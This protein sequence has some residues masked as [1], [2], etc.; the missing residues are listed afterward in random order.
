MYSSVIATILILGEY[1]GTDNILYIFKGDKY[2]TKIST[3]SEEYKMEY[4]QRWLRFHFGITAGSKQF[5]ALE[6]CLPKLFPGK[7]IHPFKSFETQLHFTIRFLEIYRD[8]FCIAWAAV[9]IACI[10]T[11]QACSTYRYD[12]MNF[13][14]SIHIKVSP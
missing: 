11:Q 9:Q 3:R 6:I 1:L 12:K 5:E 4:Y 10:Y 8:N 14:L 2:L 13:S 7:R